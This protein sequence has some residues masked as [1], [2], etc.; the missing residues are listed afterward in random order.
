ME[1]KVSSWTLFVFF[2]LGC[3]ALA[4]RHT[5]TRRNA[6][7]FQTCLES[8]DIHQ[9]KIIRTQDSRSMGAKYLNE[10]DVASRE[11]CLR[12][13]CETDSCD[14]FVFEEKSPGSC[15]LFECGTSEDFKCKFTKHQNY[16]S[17]VLAVNRQL[18]EL[19]SQIKFTQHEHELTK[20]REPSN[21]LPPPT[22][23]KS[24]TQPPKTKELA[25][26][27][28]DNGN[29]QQK[30]GC[31]KYQFECHT[32][33]ECIG[34]YNVCDG[35]P[36]CADSSD[37]AAEL[38][39]PSQQS[40]V[41]PVKTILVTQTSPS[42]NEAPQEIYPN[43]DNRNPEVLISD[44]S[45]MQW[46]QHQQYVAE[47][48]Q[49]TSNVMSNGQNVVQVNAQNPRAGYGREGEGM[50]NYHQDPQQWKVPYHQNSGQSQIFTH[51]GN[52][53]VP[54]SDHYQHPYPPPEIPRVMGGYNEQPN[55]LSKFY[56]ENG[57]YRMFPQNQPINNNWQS[58]RRIHDG[59]I[60][61]MEEGSVN[62]VEN[63]PLP[64]NNLGPDYY[65][66]EAYRNRAPPYNVGQQPV[67]N[68]QRNPASFQNKEIK[69]R[70]LTDETP[71]Q[72]ANGQKEIIST[73]APTSVVKESIS[74]DIESSH[75]KVETLSVESKV[76]ETLL[77]E[78]EGHSTNPSGA[79]LSL[80]M[81][82]CITAIMIILVGCRMRVVRRRMR[83]GGKSSYAH[84]ADFLV[85]GMYL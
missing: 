35:I 82:L 26:F 19:E 32:R 59:S 31:S 29:S 5:S 63:M 43:T 10:R 67:Y 8:F 22:T 81:G 70:V 23:V 9:D 73:I 15:Y 55:D 64:N 20:L 6:N 54:Q 45:K 76:K 7:E 3:L 48:S 42:K 53:L 39:C 46:P 68:P 80:A 56:Y 58:G 34:I 61:P 16:T 44:N 41:A 71:K 2:Q 21:P 11:D 40:T 83:R 14:V 57:P 1:P 36:Q 18:T 13:C 74:H 52:G 72:V 17:A 38:R 84:D 4:N 47:G 28:L 78:Q 33:K 79:I 25:E 66:E 24:I 27:P 77:D 51:K 30:K 69:Q 75:R 12:L 62:R 60:N 50:L 49:M 85:N 37:E 65:Y